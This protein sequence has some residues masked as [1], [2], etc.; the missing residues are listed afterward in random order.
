[1][2]LAQEGERRRRDA[3]TIGQDPRVYNLPTYV[4]HIINP[5]LFSRMASCDVSCIICLMPLTTTS[6]TFSTLAR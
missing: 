3:V 1:V 5:R 6:T 2:E 4:H